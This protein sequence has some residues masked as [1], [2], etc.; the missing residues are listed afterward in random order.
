MLTLAV[1]SFSIWLAT[2]SQSGGDAVWGNTATA[3]GAQVPV[4]EELRAASALML[5][6]YADL[7]KLI[8][9]AFAATAFLLTL[10]QKSRATIT[11]SL[12][13]LLYGG[14]VLL[15]IALFVCLASRERLLTSIAHNAVDLT[16]PMLLYGRWISYACLALAALCIGLFAVRAAEGAVSPGLRSSSE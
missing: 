12:W 15:S 14:V 16:L 4:P 10:R 8:A 2:H 7:I 5:D 3:N 11:K 6:V 1:V 9:S 13:L